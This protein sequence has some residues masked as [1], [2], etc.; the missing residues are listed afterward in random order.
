[1]YES[2]AR[3]THMHKLPVITVVTPNYNGAQFLERTI[4]SVLRQD[5]PALEY[6]IVDG[7][8]SDASESII[9]R[10]SDKLKW[11]CS[12]PD[13]GQADAISKGFSRATGEVLCWLN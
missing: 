9:Q 10:Y 6:I 12:Q 1:M 2:A 4:Q 7:G 8:S 5:Y 13:G 3:T 11:S